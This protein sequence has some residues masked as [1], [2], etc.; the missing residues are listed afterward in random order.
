V[1]NVSTEATSGVIKGVLNPV[2][3]DIKWGSSLL[4][5]EYFNYTND[6]G[7][8]QLNGVPAGYT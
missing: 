2:L 8:F 1:I 4:E 3:K 5:R 7:E 6:L